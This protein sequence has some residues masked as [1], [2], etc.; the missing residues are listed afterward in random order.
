MRVANVFFL[1]SLGASALFP[2]PGSAGSCSSPSA[3]VSA[4]YATE[5]LADASLPGAAH[6]DSLQGRWEGTLGTDPGAGL[7][8]LS[9]ARS[10]EDWTGTF[11]VPAEGIHGIPLLEVTA[12]PARIMAR[13][14]P[15]RHFEGRLM[16]DSI[17][18]RLIFQDRGGMVMDLVLHR[19]G[20]PSWDAVQA[21]LE[22]QAAERRAEPL[23][24][25]VELEVGPGQDRVNAEAL[26]RLVE[27]AEASG[28]SALVILHQGDLVGHW[29]D[30]RGERLIESM[31]VTKAVLGLAVGRLL[32]LDQLESMETPIRDFFDEWADEPHSAITLRHLLSHT[33]GLESPMP[34]TAIYQSGDFVTF[35]LHSEVVTPPGTA[36]AYNNNATNLLAGVI[37]KAA[38]QRLDRFVGETLFAPLGITDFAWSLDP[39]GNPHGMAGLQIRARDLARLG[40]LVVQDGVWEGEALLP[41][42]WVELSGTPASPL[43]DKVGLLWWLVRDGDAVVGLQADGYLGQYLVIYPEAELVGVRMIE[44]SDRYDPA[45]D[46][47]H[48]F[49][50]LLR[51]LSR[52]EASGRPE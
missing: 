17:A 8:G 1:I 23:P 45:R 6:A 9:F 2:A 34:T 42:G 4:P 41:P 5:G 25:L 40:Q 18:G 32:A 20:S 51:A 13:M 49:P 35:A 22:R 52:S 21:E 24:G 29:H 44:G 14:N 3:S 36:V 7:L 39:A 47:F 37:G 50:E 19:E 15:Q 30:Q 48:E 27:A 16:G 12:D 31:S 43:S 26:Y 38:G 28:T 10:G 46:T 33:S 11:S